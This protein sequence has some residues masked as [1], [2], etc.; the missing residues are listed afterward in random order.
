MENR[1]VHDTLQNVS[2]KGSYTARQ[3]PSRQISP[4]AP[5]AHSASSE[6]ARSVP[7]SV[8]GIGGSAE[9]SPGS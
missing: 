4:D 7:G 3:W 8:G 1:Y 9:G 2:A 6:Q 5:D